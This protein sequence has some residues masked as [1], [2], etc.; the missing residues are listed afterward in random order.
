MCVSQ[1][2]DRGFELGGPNSWSRTWC[3]DN[4]KQEAGYYWF[5]HAT[6]RGFFTEAWAI[7][8]VT[9]RYEFKTDLTVG[10]TGPDVVALQKI[11]VRKGVMVMPPGASYGF[12]GEVTRAAVARYQAQNGIA[13]VAGYFGPKTRAHLNANQ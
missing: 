2:W 12:F 7:L 8:D 6:Q 3:P 1:Y 10:H 13:P 4:K 5:L 11:L 9:D